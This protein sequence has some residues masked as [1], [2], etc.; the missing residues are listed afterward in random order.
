[1]KI[2]TSYEVWIEVPY[3]DKENI[4]HNKRWIAV[5][6]L[7]K[8][9]DKILNSNDPRYDVG[10][11]MEELELITGETGTD[12]QTGTPLYSWLPDIDTEMSKKL[13]NGQYRFDIEVGSTQKVD[14]ALITKRIENLISILAR[15]DVIALMQQQ[16]KKVDLAEVLRLWLNNSPE[17]VRD[18][19]RIIQDVSDQ[20]QGLLPAQD[21]LTGGGQGGMT[22]GSDMNAQRAQQA[23]PPVSQEQMLSEAGQ[24]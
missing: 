1:M 9:L 3:D 20:T 16:G 21:I 24:L 19:G 10:V 6:D 11:F 13:S 4:A 5:K 8:R 17:I 18:P 15:T 7:E 12:P 22:G 14:T 23:Q 2:K